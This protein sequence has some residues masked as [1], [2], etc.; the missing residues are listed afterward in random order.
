MQQGVTNYSFHST[1]MTMH[2]YYYIN[3]TLRFKQI[4]NF[5]NKNEKVK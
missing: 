5:L 2:S 3:R 1:E 4:E